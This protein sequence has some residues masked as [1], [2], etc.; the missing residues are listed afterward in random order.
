VL[1]R[2]HGDRI[3]PIAFCNRTGGYHFIARSSIS[4]VPTTF[5][6]SHIFT[7]MKFYLL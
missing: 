1:G 3:G 2:A 5:P 7:A 4:R 6:M